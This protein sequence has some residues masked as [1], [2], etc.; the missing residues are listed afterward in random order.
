MP[1][2]DII[3]GL[4]VMRSYEEYRVY[5]KKMLQYISCCSVN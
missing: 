1:P 4:N 2:C 5:T 3:H